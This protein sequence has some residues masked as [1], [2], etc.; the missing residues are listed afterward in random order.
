LQTKDLV[1]RRLCTHSNRLLGVAGSTGAL[2]S[3]IDTYKPCNCAGNWI[4]MYWECCQITSSLFF[5]L[6]SLLLFLFVISRDFH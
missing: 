6:A 1:A 4:N 2:F 5:S 3:A